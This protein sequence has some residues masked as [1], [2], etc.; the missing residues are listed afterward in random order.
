[1]RLSPSVNFFSDF[2]CA[3]HNSKNLDGW[4]LLDCVLNTLVIN[5]SFTESFNS[6]VSQQD[7]K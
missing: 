2:L 7:L 6:E 5:L 4:I 1:M 3:F